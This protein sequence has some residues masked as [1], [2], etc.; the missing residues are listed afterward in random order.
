MF[1]IYILLVYDLHSSDIINICLHCVVNV[2]YIYLY[3]Y[4]YVIYIYVFPYN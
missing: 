3:I 4:K 1:F 2:F